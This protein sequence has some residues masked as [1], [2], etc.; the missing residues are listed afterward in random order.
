MGVTSL[1]WMI[2]LFVAIL[3]L[4]GLRQ[5]F[6]AGALSFSGF[7]LGAFIGTRLGPLLLPQ[8]SASP[9]A[10]AFGLV[11]ALLAGAILATGLEGLGLRLRRVAALI[12]GAGL[13]D[14]TFGALL[15]AAVGLGIVWIIAAV[16]AQVPTAITLRADIQRSAILRGLN[17]LLPPSGPILGALA[18]LDPLPSIPRPIP[19]LAPPQPRIAADPGVR[20]AAHSVVRVLGIA[21][22]LAI[23]GSGW[24][25][26]PDEVITNAH[27]VAGESETTVEVEG[28]PPSLQAQA[29]AFD[30]TD[31]LAVLRVPGLGLPALNLLP[32]PSSGTA[33]AIL[34]YPENGSFDARAA[35]IGSTEQALTQ[36]AYGQGSVSRL[37]TPLRGLVRPGN[38][39][40]PVVDSAGEVLTTVFAGTTGGGP[41]GGYG[42]ANATVAGVLA[43]ARNPVSTGPCD[44]A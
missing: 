30:P 8:G 34:G 17:G 4:F 31:D 25:A 3:A 36:N 18:R 11:G 12:P 44:A 27:V 6:I 29:I 33:G 21:C 19:S 5:G 39:G 43:G 20:A 26:R 28:Q 40:G 15:S 7:A 10:P 38:S 9:Y 16:A 13:L 22:G 2:V 42:V 23:E 24:I 14:R 35:R 37:L 1:D 41:P 32:N